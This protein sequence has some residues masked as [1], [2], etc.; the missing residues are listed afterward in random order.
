MQVNENRPKIEVL[1]KLLNNIGIMIAAIAAA[2]YLVIVY[3]LIEGFETQH[4]QNVLEV[5]VSLGA[6]VGVLISL[7][8]RSQ[9][10]TYA[11]DTEEAK[12]QLKEYRDLKG[13]STKTKVYP[14]WIWLTISF[15]KDVLLKGVSLGATIYFSIS[16]VYEGIKDYTYLFLA[17]ANVLMF[18]GFGMMSLGGS[19]SRYMNYQIPYI[20]QKIEKLKKEKQNDLPREIESSDGQSI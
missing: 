18:I 10:I 13:K 9:G 5:F 1:T 15:I 11:R 14:I 19:Y 3:I 12:K 4:Q 20:Q 2:V 7:S 17:F 16:I 6:I 8:F